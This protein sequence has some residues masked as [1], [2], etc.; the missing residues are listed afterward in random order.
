MG[1][2]LSIG[3]PDSPRVG[4]AAIQSD[5]HREWTNPKNSSPVPN[6]GELVLVE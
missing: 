4:A 1:D 3:V 5:E 6:T 2:V